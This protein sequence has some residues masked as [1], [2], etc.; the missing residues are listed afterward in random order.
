MVSLLESA[1][2][3][4]D[5]LKEAQAEKRETALCIPCFVHIYDFEIRR[6]KSD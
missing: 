3:L 5:V 4:S 1:G 2:Y 6:Q